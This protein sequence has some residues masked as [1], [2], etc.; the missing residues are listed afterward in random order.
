MRLS[1]LDAFPKVQRN[2]QHATHTGGLVTLLVA[3]LL[4]YLAVSEFKAYRDIRQDY[5]FVVDET[6]SAEHALQIN[7]DLTIAMPCSY[8]RA[9]VLDVAGTSLPISKSLNVEKVV[10]ETRGTKRLGYNADK[11]K[12]DIHKLV[13]QAMRNRENDGGS[14][15]RG[16]E[17]EACRITGSINV[18]KVSGMLHFTALGHGY[19]GGHT[20]HEAMNFTHRIDRMSFGP[21]Y[22]GLRNPLDR[23]LEVASTK[24]DM[25]QY[26]IAIVPTI[27]ID[28]NRA[29]GK[30]ALLTS[31]YAVTDYTR[32]L[33]V[34]NKQGGLPGVF[35]KYEI[36]PILVRITE[37]RQGFLHFLTRL[38]G[39]IG[40]TCI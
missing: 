10:F 40:G 16:E 9:D 38:C 21:N 35:I 36:E 34:D 14:T 4:A 18:N 32:S 27:Y 22:P 13:G 30:R 19:F 17:T 25:F 31:Q 24:M 11:P 7:M 37:S 1:N 5:E 20:P 23:T 15:I 26:F 12:M 2:I 33:T 6:R 8:L 3:G 29:F 28:R 39:I